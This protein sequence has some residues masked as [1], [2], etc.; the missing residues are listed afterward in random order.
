MG[1][2]LYLLLFVV[3]LLLLG[4]EASSFARL[5][6]TSIVGSE[7]KRKLRMVDMS[8]LLTPNIVAPVSS[9][10]ILLIVG[11]YIM[12]LSCLISCNSCY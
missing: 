4:R 9:K 6:K 8:T 11:I 5:S 10:S 7:S 2:C 3:V 12:M 1:G